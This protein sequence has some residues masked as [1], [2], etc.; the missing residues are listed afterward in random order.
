MVTWD[1]NGTGA[2]AAISSGIFEQR[3]HLQNVAPES[4]TLAGAAAVT[5]SGTLGNNFD[6]GALAAFDAERRHR[7]DVS[8][9]RR[10]RKSDHKF[11]G[12]DHRRCPD[13]LSRIALKNGVTLDSS[14]PQGR[15]FSFNVQATDQ[16]GAS[17]VQTH[18]L[19]RQHRQQHPGCDQGRR[20][21]GARHRRAGHRRDGIS[22]FCPR[23]TRTACPRSPILS[24][25]RVGTPSRTHRS[26][27]R[28]AM[29]QAPSSSSSRIEVMLDR[30]AY[31]NG[32]FTLYC[33]RHGC[34]RPYQLRADS[35]TVRKCHRGPDDDHDLRTRVLQR[36]RRNSHHRNVA[37]CRW[38]PGDLYLFADLDRRGRQ[39]Q[40][41]R[42][43]SRGNLRRSTGKISKRIGAFDYEAYANGTF[44][45]KLH[46][47]I[48]GVCR[49]GIRA[50]GRRH[51]RQRQRSADG[52]R[53]RHSRRDTTT[54]R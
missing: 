9:R 53:F 43:R 18:Q 19:R 38:R 45:F 4:I 32:V 39:H 50:D 1:G 37:A 6:F 25:I 5:Y 31:A 41:E 44:T 40:S 20:R 16:D 12:R 21:D 24:S 15:N 17:F 14:N 3:F 13:G 47:E 28:R 22:E 34:G 30:E 51:D 48:A 27:L 8:A 11:P 2:N 29:R 7:F 23:R 46:A 54:S 52:Y 35:V 10:R 36:E 42:R 26:K 33:A 49:D